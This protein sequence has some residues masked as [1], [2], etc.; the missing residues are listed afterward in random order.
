[1]FVVIFSRRF[2]CHCEYIDHICCLRLADL[3]TL[4][5]LKV[6]C[7]LWKG[8]QVFDVSAIQAR[9]MWVDLH[10]LLNL[11]YRLWLGMVA[12]LRDNLTRRR[13][14]L[15]TG[16]NLEIGSCSSV[17]SR[18]INDYFFNSFNCLLLLCRSVHLGDR[19]RLRVFQV[20]FNVVSL[21]KRLAC[22]I[23]LTLS[24]FRLALRFFLVWLDMSLVFDTFI[25]RLGHWRLWRRL[26]LLV[27]EI[28][29]LFCAVDL[30]VVLQNLIRV[31]ANFRYRLLVN[32]SWGQDNL[33][34]VE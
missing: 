17:C 7:W 31:G 1:M 8:T 32:K 33:R 25:C 12:L 4:L 18:R 16:M 14:E 28:E 19:A 13:D 6:R 15:I 2:L 10:V 34:L 26:E 21:S 3:V 30:S 23:I 29:F 27:W 11:R 24:E 9:Q 20:V 5:D 22:G